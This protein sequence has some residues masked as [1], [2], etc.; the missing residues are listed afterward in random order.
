MFLF[1]DGGIW[2]QFRVPLREQQIIYSFYNTTYIIHLYT[3]NSNEPWFLWILWFLNPNS[4]RTGGKQPLFINENPTRNLDLPHFG[5]EWCTRAFGRFLSPGTCGNDVTLLDQAQG[6]L[7]FWYL[8][9]WTCLYKETMLK[10]IW[11]KWISHLSKNYIC[12]MCIIPNWQITSTERYVSPASASKSTSFFLTLFVYDNLWYVPARKYRWIAGWEVSEVLCG[13]SW[14][15]KRTC[16]QCTVYGYPGR[17]V[18]L[19]VLFGG[20]ERG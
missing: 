20:V 15:G 13:F 11:P 12:Y 5:H 17:T 2:C 10:V 9:A 14:N 18:W 4:L 19:Q 8:K 6:D 3:R 7:T 16:L 1:R